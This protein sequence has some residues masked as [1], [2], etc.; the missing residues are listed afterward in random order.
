MEFDED[1]E[2]YSE[3]LDQ[4]MAM[5]IGKFNEGDLSGAARH[6]VPIWKENP[7]HQRA[8]HNIR[9]LATKLLQNIPAIPD[10][11]PV[12]AKAKV[13]ADAEAA[14]ESVD[15]ANTN[16]ACS[17]AWA[18]ADETRHIFDLLTFGRMSKACGGDNL[19]MKKA[20][21]SQAISWLQDLKIEDG[22]DE[23]EDDED[24]DEDE[25]DAKVKAFKAKEDRAKVE[26]LL[27]DLYS[28]LG[29][30]E[31]SF[32]SFSRAHDQLLSEDAAAQNSKG[33]AAQAETLLSAFPLER[34][35]TI[36]STPSAEAS[37]ASAASAA[38][39]AS[40]G[41]A[42]LK[43]VF[44]FG[45]PGAGAAL[46]EK[47][48]AST[49]GTDSGAP[50][51][52]SL[53]SDVRP[54]RMLLRGIHGD[55]A[56]NEMD[57]GAFLEYAAKVSTGAK[58]AAAGKRPLSFIENLRQQSA[59]F[60]HAQAAEL[61]KAQQEDGASEAA[62]EPPAPLLVTSAAA[63]D[64]V[65][66]MLVPIVFPEAKIIWLERCSMDAAWATFA[67]PKSMAKMFAGSL[68]ALAEAYSAYQ[69]TTAQ[70]KPLL[71]AVHQPM[72][73]VHFED[74]IADPVATAGS[75]LDFLDFGAA[76]EGAAAAAVAKFQFPSS[77][78][79]FQAFQ[80]S[81]RKPGNA[82][83]VPV[84][85]VPSIAG[86]HDGEPWSLPP[87]GGGAAPV[88]SGSPTVS[89]GWRKFAVFLEP[90]KAALDAA[91]PKETHAACLA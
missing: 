70:L 52:V 47:I 39:S 73:S 63:L 50:A 89:G 15:L 65:L 56:K 77:E 42:G 16:L 71:E 43:P 36:L 22:G 46:V 75:I 64:G 86:A 78:A 31:R 29:V 40:S 83:A 11:E 3:R 48:I 58:S 24:G 4:A 44:I 88:S 59:G 38:A 10:F 2:D 85:V 32:Q 19:Q 87:A 76:A 62:P 72:L 20:A 66:A 69:T 12:A 80:G 61:W 55:A 68:G 30:G 8:L 14:T 17:V 79:V 67:S 82:T 90:L 25:D 18:V 57:V 54:L 60:V 74:L 9:A 41:T 27:A 37:A 6:L 1:E 34:L 84:E 5:A 45:F 51:V 33:L 23:Q 81:K 7:M 49:A 26:F 91:L 53:G 21:V 28:F 35:A 13:D